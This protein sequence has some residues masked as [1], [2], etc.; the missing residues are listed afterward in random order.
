MEVVELLDLLD[1][2]TS[3][4]GSVWVKRR[5]QH[6]AYEAL[7]PL[8]KAYEENDKYTY[9]QQKSLD[10]PFIREARNKVAAIIDAVKDEIRAG[11]TAVLWHAFHDS[12]IRCRHWI[13]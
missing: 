4:C 3:I 7:I 10:D 12:G 13:R 11:R 6:R 8:A 1:T 5:G 9:R 2:A